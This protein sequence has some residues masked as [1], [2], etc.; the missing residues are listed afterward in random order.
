LNDFRIH[1]K[2]VASQGKKASTLAFCILIASFKPMRQFLCFLVIALA[3][4][5]GPDAPPPK[6]EIPGEAYASPIWHSD[7][8]IAAVTSGLHPEKREILLTAIRNCINRDL[9]QYANHISNLQKTIEDRVRVLYAAVQDF[10]EAVDKEDG[11]EDGYIDYCANLLA[12]IELL[13]VQLHHI[14]DLSQIRLSM[15]KLRDSLKE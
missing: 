14:E 10:E 6:N 9:T 12:E 13:R 15:E 11:F 2:N 3:A 1:A 5:A 8:R 4:C 7:S